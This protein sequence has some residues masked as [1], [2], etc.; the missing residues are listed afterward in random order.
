MSTT[1]TLREYN[2]VTYRDGLFHFGTM[3][4]KTAAFLIAENRLTDDDHAPLMDL[5][6]EP[7]EPLPKLEDVVRQWEEWWNSWIPDQRSKAVRGVL[8]NSLCS[9]LRAAFPHID[10][11]EGA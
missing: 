9:R 7:Y 5:K 10:T 1:R 6:K 3:K 8:A 2:G 4:Y 11:P